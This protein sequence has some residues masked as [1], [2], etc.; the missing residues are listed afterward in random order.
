MIS[1]TVL[2]WLTLVALVGLSLG[3]MVP[4]ASAAFVGTEI[5]ACGLPPI[6]VAGNF[7][8][9]KNLTATGTD[10]IRV[11][12]SNVAIDMNGHKITGDGTHSGITDNCNFVEAVAISHGKISDFDDGI[13]FCDGRVITIERVDSSDNKGTGIFI[14]NSDDDLTDVRADRNGESGI[15]VDGSS[16]EFNNIE[17]NDNKIDGIFDGSCCAGLDHV[18][19]NHNGGDGLDMEDDDQVVADVRTIGNGGHGMFFCCV[20][21][22]VAKAT[23]SNNGGDGM[24]FEDFDNRVSHSTA[25]DN[26][27]VGM[28]LHV[29]GDNE[30]T[31]VIANHNTTGVVLNC[32]FTGGNAVRVSA[33]GNT[34][35]LSEI[36]PAFCTNL[37]NSAP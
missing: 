28:D 22:V 4:A 29:G 19:A 21:N 37:D 23:A 30:V 2:R 35:N 11:H 20:D 26:K 15:D 27:S 3:V 10:C 17:A 6:T 34:T 1:K 25:N 16:V 9:K 24:E 7:F 31:D 8:L 14:E 36:T 33:H 13:D 5:T 12:H 18:T 32:S